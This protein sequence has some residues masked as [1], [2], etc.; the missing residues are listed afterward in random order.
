MRA[1]L[2]SNRFNTIPQRDGRALALSSIAGDTHGRPDAPVTLSA[3]RRRRLPGSFPAGR[4]RSDRGNRGSAGNTA[5]RQVRIAD[6]LPG[7]LT[8]RLRPRR[9]AI[10]R[11]RIAVGTSSRLRARINSPKPGMMP[12]A[13]TACV[14]SGVT[15]RGLG[16]VPPVVR[17]SEQRSTS[18]S[19]RNAASICPRS[20]GN[21]P[22]R[23]AAR[24]SRGS[25]PAPPRCPARPCLRRGP[26][27]RGRKR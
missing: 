20:S 16:P 11:D 13:D 1:L 2:L 4:R 25:P 23:R 22:P 18:A 26:P 3:E 27:K 9:P 24:A 7:R 19:S 15:S 5:S 17:I 21:E 14:A 10:W 8:I 6:G 12:V